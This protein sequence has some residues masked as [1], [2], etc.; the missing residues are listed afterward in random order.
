[1]EMR[2]KRMA[3][4]LLRTSESFLVEIPTKKNTVLIIQFYESRTA[5]VIGFDVKMQY[6]GKII[7][8]SVQKRKKQVW[9]CS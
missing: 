6:I 1:M 2:A 4:C 5:T 9:K 3:D 7:Q 8:R